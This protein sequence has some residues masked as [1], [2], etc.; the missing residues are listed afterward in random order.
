[1][2]NMDNPE[3]TDYA[4]QICMD[5]FHESPIDIQRQFTGISS[6]VYTLSF[7]E[8]KYIL[9]ISPEKEL[10]SGSAYW[11]E[12]LAHLALPIPKIIALCR[13]LCRSA[14]FS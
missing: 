12:R 11:L 9:K 8:G 10:V 13:I 14:R 1:M 7:K 2:K 5:V 6:Y 4:K 3:N